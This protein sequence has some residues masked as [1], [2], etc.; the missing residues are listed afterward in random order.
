MEG[1]GTALINTVGRKWCQA[2]SEAD[3]EQV[4]SPPGAPRTHALE[5]VRVEH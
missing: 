4:Q 1:L 3:S 5:K 2:I